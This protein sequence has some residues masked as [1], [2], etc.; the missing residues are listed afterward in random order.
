MEC[1]FEFL[2]GGT[3][4]AYPVFCIIV[5]CRASAKEMQDGTAYKGIMLSDF[6]TADRHS[7]RERYIPYP[8]YGFRKSGHT[9]L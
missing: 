7:V 9:A 2:S 1:R 4:A 8:A 5:Y 6:D 3:A